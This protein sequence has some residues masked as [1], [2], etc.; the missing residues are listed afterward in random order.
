MNKPPVNPGTEEKKEAIRNLEF[1]LRHWPE[2]VEEAELTLK[3]T[4]ITTALAAL[5]GNE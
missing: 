3:R 4:T 1:A 5:K 2:D